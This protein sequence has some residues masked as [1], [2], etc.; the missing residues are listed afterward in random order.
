MKKLLCLLALLVAPALYGATRHVSC[1]PTGTHSCADSSNL[2]TPDELWTVMGPGS[3]PDEIIL[4]YGSRLTTGRYTGAACMFQP[5][6][7]ID[8][9]AGHPISVQ[10][11]DAATGVPI[12]I[13]AGYTRQRAIDMSGHS[14]W[15]INGVAACC[16]GPSTS[17]VGAWY[18]GPNTSNV[19]VQNSLCWDVTIDYN[20]QCYQMVGGVLSAYPQAN[21]GPVTIDTFAQFGLGRK[22]SSLYATRGNALMLMKRGVFMWHGSTN[23]GPKLGSSKN[24]HSKNS[25]DIDNVY[26]WPGT[27]IPSTYVNMNNGAP[28]PTNTSTSSNSIAGS[29]SKVFTTTAACS[30]VVSSTNQDIRVLRHS[31]TTTYMQ[32]TTTCIGSTLTLTVT[33]SSGAG[34]PYTD[35]DVALFMKNNTQLGAYAALGFDA[36]DTAHDGDSNAIDKLYGGIALIRNADQANSTAPRGFFA[37]NMTGITI[38]DSV[39]FIGT[40]YPTK[41]GFLLAGCPNGSGPPFAVCESPTLSFATRITSVG[42]A[43]DTITTGATGFT[44]TDAVHLADNST[45]TYDGSS[46]TSKAN[47]CYLHDDSGVI[48]GTARWPFPLQTALS[49]YMTAFGYTAINVQ[50]EVVALG[51]ALPAACDASV[52]TPT[53]TP[54]GVLTN[55]PTPTQTNTPTTTRTPTNTRTRTPTPLGA[56]T[57]TPRDCKHKWVCHGV[58]YWSCT[59]KDCP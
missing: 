53:S 55:T 32:G 49:A 48:T 28:Y 46:G 39:A 34:G 15:T 8:G 4:L 50:A 21:W 20:I 23:Q 1:S 57:V 30:N 22:G 19:I 9:T 54:T 16:I 13:D 26:M 40:S 42:G 59:R 5:D 7:G 43:A 31:A 41:Q 47:I 10:T 24:Y 11:V 44:K 17:S 37:T 6:A 38:Q 3:Y 56:A 51:G 27:S 58:V 33:S 14:Y 35:W 36:N 25:T 29:G 2:C 12:L 45:F 52:A 18:F